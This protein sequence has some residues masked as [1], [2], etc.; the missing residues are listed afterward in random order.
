MML[1]SGHYGRSS[2][3]P[4]NHLT[5]QN[6]E[7][8]VTMPF[9]AI[10]VGLLGGVL[11]G[12]ISGAYLQQRITQRRIAASESSAARILN[13]AESRQKEIL[14]EAKEESIRFR[15]QAEAELKT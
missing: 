6:K 9:I 4:I 13:E 11:L 7:A 5:K 3:N 15:Q 10:G 2:P 14:L 8:R 12:V 1:L